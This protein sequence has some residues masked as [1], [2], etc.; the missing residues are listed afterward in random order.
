[1]LTLDRV[2]SIEDYE[3]FARAFSGIGKAQASS[4]LSGETQF[5]QVTVAAANGDAVDPVSDLFRSLAGAIEAAH[6]PAQRFQVASYQKVLFNLKGSVLIDN[7]FKAADVLTA[8]SNTLLQTFSFESR[9]FAQP[10]TAAEVITVMQQVPGVIATLLTQL[11]FATDSTGPSQTEPAS[12]LKSERA[13]IGG[14]VVQPA[15]MVFI[16]PA[17]ADVT[18]MKP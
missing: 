5:V 12:F 17:G 15:Q 8:V 9:E 18:E 16:N 11:Y 3:T 6:D 7:R 10:V 2:V 13:R 4:L 14:G 1:V